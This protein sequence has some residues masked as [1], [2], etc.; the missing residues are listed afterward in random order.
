MEAKAEGS[1]VTL[2]VAGEKHVLTL[3]EA[4]ALQTSLS[5]AIQEVLETKIRAVS[6]LLITPQDQAWQATIADL[7]LDSHA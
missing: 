4:A 2:H 5:V 7:D 6:G 1:S 3:Q